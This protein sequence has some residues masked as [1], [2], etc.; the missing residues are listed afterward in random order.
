MP[1]KII[2]PAEQNLLRQV[3]R[4]RRINPAAEFI[5]NGAQEKVI[6]AVG[7]WSLEEC[8]IRT[9]LASFSNGV[10]KTA[11]AVNIINSI[12]NGPSSA[13]FDY[14]VFRSWPVCR[15]FRVVGTPT[16]LAE[17]GSVTIEMVKWLPAGSYTRVK[18]GKNIYSNYTFSRGYTLQILTNK[19]D[20]DE[21]A[22]PSRGFTWID[23][24][25]TRP[26]WQECVA[27]HRNGGGILLITATLVSKM[28]EWVDEDIMDREDGNEI[29]VIEAD[30]EANCR[31]HGVRGIR[32]HAEI[33]AMDRLLSSDPDVAAVRMGGAASITE[34][35]KVFKTFRDKPIEKVHVRHLSEFPAIDRMTVYQGLDP[36]DDKPWAM[37]WMGIDAD[38]NHFILAE[39]PDTETHEVPYHRMG[40]VVFG[41]DHYVQEI[42]RIEHKYRLTGRVYQRFIDGR[43]ASKPEIGDRDKRSLQGILLEDYGLMFHLG[44]KDR[45]SRA[46]AIPILE[47]LLSWDPKIYRAGTF[48]TIGAPKLFFAS[49][50]TNAIRAMARHARKRV[51]DTHSKIIMAK[52]ERMVYKDFVDVM[53]L[54]TEHRPA[55]RGPVQVG[56]RAEKKRVIL[57]ELTRY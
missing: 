6:R 27:R 44:S 42:L 31:E 21:F 18:E 8:P 24:P 30:A 57:N 25:C 39:W 43:F 13:W 1:S 22:G 53:V 29:I 26:Q 55:Y 50:C 5:P 52:D 17:Q 37:A 46:H 28:S 51:M 19:Q 11:V 23:E 15:D 48:N 49:H 34:R 32:S 4:G 47:Q 7:T 45:Q 3:L 36:H 33:E 9:I 12:V 41:L 14:P 38:Y 56:S 35:G 40:S 10:G 2:T 16:N 54:L 20:V